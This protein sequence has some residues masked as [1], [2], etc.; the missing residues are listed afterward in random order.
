[1]D[2]EKKATWLERVEDI[3][4]VLEGSTVSELELTED[5]IEITIRR[6]PGMVMTAATSSVVTADQAAAMQSVG[7]PG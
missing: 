2:R 4:D 5:G 7:R 6:Q 3:I 1:M